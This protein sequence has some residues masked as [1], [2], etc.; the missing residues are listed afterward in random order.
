[1]VINGVYQSMNMVLI[2]LLYG[3]DMVMI[4]LQFGYKCSLSVHEYGIIW[5]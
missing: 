1:M 5:L 2:W 4:W 3:Y